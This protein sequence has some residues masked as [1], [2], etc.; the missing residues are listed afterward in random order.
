[1]PASGGK[2]KGASASLRRFLGAGCDDWRPSTISKSS[3]QLS[4]A[5][6]DE[7]GS[8][9]IDSCNEGAS[10]DR[11]RLARRVSSLNHK[12]IGRSLGGP[13]CLA[14]ARPKA[15]LR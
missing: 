9:L 14:M 2:E 12:E 1:L 7:G 6:I 10:F 8:T 15:R 13:A 4:R 5:G 3:P 11:V